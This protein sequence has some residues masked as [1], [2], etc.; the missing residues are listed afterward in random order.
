MT[1][2]S[3]HHESPESREGEPEEK[4]ELHCEPG[5]MAVDGV[6]VPGSERL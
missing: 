1:S 5:Y 4:H 3:H 6:C 2:S